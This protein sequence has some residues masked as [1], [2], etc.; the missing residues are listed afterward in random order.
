MTALS[1]GI[2]EYFFAYRRRELPRKRRWPSNLMII[3]TGSV[4]SRLILPLGLSSVALW[5]KGHHLGLFNY[6]KVSIIAASIMTFLLLDYA[7]YLQHVFSHRWKILWIFHRVHHTD[8]DLDFTTALRFHPVEILLSLVFKSTVIIFI[9]AN[10]TSVLVFEIVLN[11]M[12]MFNHTNLNIPHRFERQ[13]RKFIV[14]PQ[15][16]IIHHS[17]EKAE[18]DKN[19]G[20]NLSFW[21]YFFNSYQSGFHSAGIIGQRETNIKMDQRILKLLLQPFKQRIR[22]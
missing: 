12:A 17:V 2:A 16:H 10:V 8:P 13:L 5:A 9:G 1:L 4:L 21:D 11:S 19:F 6:F 14:T 3:V 15:M 22:S 20:F 7:I 18:S